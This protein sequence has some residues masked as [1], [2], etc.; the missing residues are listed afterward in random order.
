MGAKVDRM[1]HI[2]GLGQNL[3]NHIIAPCVG[4]CNLRFAFPGAAP[5]LCQISRR[6][7]HL[8]PI[9]NICDVTQPMP[10]NSQLIDAPHD[11]RR[12]L[13]NQPVILV[14][15]IFLV[16]V[17]GLVGDRLARFTLDPDSGALFATQV[18]QVPLAHDIDKRCELTGAGVVAVNAVPNSNKV[19][20][21][22]FEN[23]LCVETSLEVISPYSAEVFYQEMC[24]FPGFN[25][26]D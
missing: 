7:F 5:L 1:A 18:A 17:D 4:P 12:F 2:F 14:V 3:P 25:V 10:L 24:Y 23:D 16:A 6:G 19:D 15:G 9:Q 21:V 8:V 20:A 11:C 13:I 22:A 26:S